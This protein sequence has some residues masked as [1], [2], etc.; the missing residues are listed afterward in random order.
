MTIALEEFYSNVQQYIESVLK[1]ENLVIAQKDQPAI[2]MEPIEH[3]IN[4]PR[5]Y[6]LAKGKIFIADDF[7]DPLPDY[8]LDEFEGK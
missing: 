3:E 2:R 1:G 8:I 6:G 5:P 7:D 4:Q